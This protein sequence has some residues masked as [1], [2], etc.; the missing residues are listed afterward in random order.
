M[1]YTY[2]ILL[3]ILF[4]GMNCNNGVKEPVM[5]SEVVDF[6]RFHIE[7]EKLTTCLLELEH[8]NLKLERLS[9]APRKTLQIENPNMG[10]TIIFND[11]TIKK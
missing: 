11:T 3:L 6:D 4:S 5:Y 2:T 8:I 10:S 7:K 1:K 9:K